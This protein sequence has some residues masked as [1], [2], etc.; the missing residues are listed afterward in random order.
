M[1]LLY[2]GQFF[3]GSTALHRMES[4]GAQAGVQVIPHQV[5]SAHDAARQLLT[6]VRWRLRWPSDVLA[7]NA[8]LL[9]EAQRARP[10]VVLID[11]SKVI[12]RNTLKR[13]RLLGSRVLAY[14]SPDDIIA[15]HNLSWPLRLSFPEWDIFFTTK[16]VNVDELAVRGVR[17]PHLIGNA[18]CPRDHRPFAPEQVGPEFERFDLVFIGTYERSRAASILRLAQ[19]GMSV[20]VYGNDAGTRARWHAIQHPNIVLRPAVY[21]EDYSRCLHHG[22]IA[23]CFLRKAN[24]DQITTRSIEIA[25][26]AR[27]MLAEK[28]VEHDAHFIDDREYIGFSSDDLLV[29]SARILLDDQ[30]RRAALATAGRARCVSSGYDTDHRAAE[31]VIEIERTFKRSRA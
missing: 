6:R 19:A 26:A 4:F 15:R 29:A 22:K 31:M 3:P 18:F 2:H 12:S 5:G 13:L 17:R 1:K 30:G 20:V 23:L 16:S 10:D 8:R 7:E 27:P 9:D 25:A 14:Y 28:T 24:R 11:N 21:A